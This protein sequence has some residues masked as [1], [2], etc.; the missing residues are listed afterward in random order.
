MKK[1]YLSTCYIDR[2]N[3]L[4]GKLYI[5]SDKS[6]YIDFGLKDIYCNNKG[7]LIQERPFE[8]LEILI[9]SYNNIVLCDDIAYDIWPDSDFSEDKEN[10]E[11]QMIS[12]AVSYLKNQTDVGNILKGL[13]TP[14][15]KGGY[16]F[17][18]GENIAI[19]R[20]NIEQEKIH[21]ITYALSDIPKKN[22]IDYIVAK[23]QVEYKDID[24][25]ESTKSSK[26]SDNSKNKRC[27]AADEQVQ[28]KR[29]IEKRDLLW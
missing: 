2:R 3:D 27:F 4:V 17:Q 28:Q 24:K 16:A 13:I 19:K 22:Q 5:S 26:N 18:I 7:L 9:K 12:N 11:N 20:L 6:I 25:N 14:K 23:R 29:T 21:D 10:N 15:R 8:I 1:R